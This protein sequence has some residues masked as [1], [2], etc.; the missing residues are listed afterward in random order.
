MATMLQKLLKTFKKSMKKK[1]LA[2]GYAEDGSKRFKM[3]T[4]T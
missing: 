3:E 1:Q 2:N 4:S